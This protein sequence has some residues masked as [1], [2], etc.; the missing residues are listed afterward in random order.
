MGLDEVNKRVVEPLEQGDRGDGGWFVITRVH[1]TA[2]RLKDIA[3]YLHDVGA[4]TGRT[5]SNADYNAL[6]EAVGVTGADPVQPPPG[7]S[8]PGRLTRFGR[9]RFR[10]T[11]FRL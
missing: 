5:L 11:A 1:L 10:R 3:A 9:C 4:E 8:C 6:A 2:A 7:G